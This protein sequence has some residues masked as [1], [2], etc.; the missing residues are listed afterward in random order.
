MKRWFAFLTM[1]DLL[2]ATVDVPPSEEYD[3]VYSCFL[4]KG[5]H[6]KTTFCHLF[7]LQL[8]H[9]DDKTSTLRSLGVRQARLL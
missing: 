5:N 8:F 7:T 9:E 3:P 4:K 1:S 6:R 2:E